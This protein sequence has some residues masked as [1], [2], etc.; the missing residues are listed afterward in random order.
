MN[1]KLWPGIIITILIAMIGWMI[2]LQANKAD[3]LEAKDRWTSGQMDEYKEAQIEYK[4]F[5]EEKLDVINLKLDLL[6]GERGTQ[7]RGSESE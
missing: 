2:H 6:L 4:K 5:I 7:V 1:D 3:K